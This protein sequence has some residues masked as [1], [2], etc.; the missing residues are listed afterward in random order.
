[1]KLISFTVNSTPNAATRVGALINNTVVDFTAALPY[2]SMLSF[3]QGGDQATRQAKQLIASG[4]YRQPLHSCTLKA[5]ITN[6][7]KILCVGMNYR[8]HC[9]EQDMP[10]P[11]EPLI[12]SKF[13]STITHPNAPIRFDSRLTQKMDWEVE[14]CIVIGKEVPRNTR[15]ADAM[16]YV[17]GYTV[18]HDVS[19]RDWQMEKNGG[20]WLLGKSMDTFSPIGPC[21]TTTEE[22]GDKIYNTGVRCF[23][24][25]NLVQDS[26]TNQLVF[27]APQ[28]IA[29][30]SKFITM[31]PGDL[32]FTGTPSGVGAFR[33][34][35]VWL[36]HGDVVKVEIDGLGS[37]T[38]TCMDASASKL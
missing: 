31:K 15:E 14:M 19:A 18:A 26:N 27:A 11:T 4:K 21:I 25:G 23:V 7:E 20:Q 30:I 6:P 16:P 35:P 24:N 32:I 22:M 5:P 10:I 1:M 12:F 37:V 9:I 36:K 29:W 13:A 34:P 17:A 8:E 3:L 38:N 2:H 33:N 28:L